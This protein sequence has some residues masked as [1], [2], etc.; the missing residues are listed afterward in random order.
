MTE[1]VLNGLAPT[2]LS[3]YLGA[4]GLFR[5]VAEQLD[6]GIAAAWRRDQFLLDGLDLDQL[7]AFLTERFEPSPVFSPWNKEGDP[8]QNATTASQL[9]VIVGSGQ[10]RFDGYRTTLAAWLDVAKDP[11]WISGDKTTR[12]T[13]WRAAVPD[14]ALGWMDAAVVLGSEKAEFPPLLGSGGNDGRFEFSRLL[15]GELIRLFV[16]SKQ[17]ARSETWLRAFLTGEPGPALVDSTSGMYDSDAAGA[18]N[19]APQGSAKS[20]SNPWSIVFTFEGLIAFGASVASRLGAGQRQLV[21]AP[22]MVRASRLGGESA[23]HE[24]ARGEL[25]APLWDRPATWREVRRTI[26]EGRL[27]WQGRQA[28]STVD[29]TRAVASL[30]V[31]RGIATFVR[32][33]IVQRNGKSYLATPVG[34][35]EVRGVTGTAE[36][37]AIDPWVR[38]ARRIGGSAVDAAALRLDRAQAS[39]VASD[40]SPSAFAEVLIALADLEVAVGRTVAGRK[41]VTPFPVLRGGVPRLDAVTWTGLAD[42]GSAEVRVAAGLASLQSNPDGG[43]Y[44]WMSLALRGVAGTPA[45]P[46]WAD[47]DGGRDADGAA[48]TRLRDNVAVTVLQR[49]LHAAAQVHGADPATTPVAGYRRGLWVPLDDVLGLLDGRLAVERVLRLARG[50][51]LLDGW[52]PAQIGPTLRRSTQEGS[53]F[54]PVPDPW[55]SAVRLC[56]VDRAFATRSNASGADSSVHPLPRRSWGRL[57]AAGRFEQIGSDA[58]TTLSRHDLTSLRRASPVGRP[59]PAAASVALLV[60]LSPFDLL[61]LTTSIA[62]PPPHLPSQGAQP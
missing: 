46:A 39:V 38:E 53:E 5:V 7:V 11:R 47:S 21:G 13:L 52:D 34:R 27:A 62:D 9:E 54:D 56:L 43:P 36:L 4:L 31:D 10:T 50:M 57:L 15:H 14:D 58:L 26:G 8:D 12:L 45:K 1:L 42:D 24:D 19:S 41:K 18:P 60:R 37:G 51:A 17:S 35:V 20:A 28:G 6:S 55:F 61:R 44:T 25:W 48:A 16:D 22:F 30:G 49:R 3:G 32:H 33:Q 23:P 40:G 29:A 59:D 2:P